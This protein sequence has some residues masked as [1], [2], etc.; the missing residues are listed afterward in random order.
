MNHKV[1]VSIDIRHVICFYG[2]LL[3]ETIGFE[4]SMCETPE[5]IFLIINFNCSVMLLPWEGK[6]CH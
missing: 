6:I 5:N 1:F 2:G 3:R 4:N